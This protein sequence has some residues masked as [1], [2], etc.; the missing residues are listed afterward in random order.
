[1][2]DAQPSSVA[3]FCMEIALRSDIPSYS[4]GL[5][6][7]A[8]DV[9]RAAADAGLPMIGV[10]LL[11]RR[12]HFRQELDAD[13]RQTEEPAP[14]EPEAV[15]E[16]LPAR[17]SVQVEGR[18]VTARAWRYGVAGASGH[19]VPVYL[20][21]TGLEENS[22]EDR[23]LTDSLYGGD[24]RYRLSQETVLGLGGVALIRALGHSGIT[25]FHMNEGH[26]ALLTLALIEEGHPN[27]DEV[28]TASEGDIERVRAACVF[29]THTPVPAGHDRFAADLVTHVLGERRARLAL[30]LAGEAG[31]LN[32][33]DLALH[34]SRYTN[35]VSLRHEEVTRG[36]FPHFPIASVTNGVHAATW[37]SDPLAELFDSHLPGWRLYNRRLLAAEDL[38]RALIRNA[39]HAAKAELLAEVQAR[40]SVE[41]NPEALTVGFAR[42]ATGYKRADLL[43][44]DIERLRAI[45]R[46]IGPLQVLYAGKAHPRDY[47]G[48]AIISR[49]FAAARTLGDDVR[50]VYLEDYGMDLAKRLCAGVDLWLNTPIRPREAS[51]T[52]GMKAALNGVPS[53]SILDGWWV[54]GHTEGVTGWA[55]G[56]AEE[57]DPAADARS[58]YDK[59]EHTIAPMFFREPD[60]YAA[61][62]RS[63]IAR[64]GSYFTGERMVAEYAR[65]AYGLPL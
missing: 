11:Y 38:P 18:T 48:K 24:E 61:V 16:E 26:S 32:M 2:T 43:F 29:T 33:T 37:V 53:L 7:L 64:N 14:W 12:G 46:N 62:M 60:Y 54:E 59:L 31:M 3:Y 17:V 22:P 52:S 21:D 20:L 34:L 63:A 35:A 4:G 57:G 36:M 58:L 9:L 15:L 55:I 50:V 25:T 30:T 13:G 44:S 39:H 28:W 23:A 45:A 41:L 49:V 27:G 6:V 47:E 1:M 8:G 19:V 40:T 51:G 65:Q 10:T 56:G 42:R 5:G